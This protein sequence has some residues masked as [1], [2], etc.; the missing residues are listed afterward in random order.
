MLSCSSGCELQ[1]CPLFVYVV[2][3]YLTGKR[4]ADRNADFA[5]GIRQ[6]MGFDWTDADLTEPVPRNPQSRPEGP[7]VFVSLSVRHNAMVVSP[8][9]FAHKPRGIH[10]FW[11]QSE[12]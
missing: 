11:P 4:S 2:R 5:H 9:G 6:D 1:Y 7:I 8:V 10:Q 3:N 12:R